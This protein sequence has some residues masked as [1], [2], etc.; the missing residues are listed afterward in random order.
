MSLYR[1]LL[2]FHIDAQRGQFIDEVV[3]APE[4][5]GVLIFSRREAE[6][7]WNLFFVDQLGQALVHQKEIAA[8][9]AARGREPVWY[10]PDEDDPRLPDAAQVVG[11]NTWMIR[12]RGVPWQGLPAG[13]SLRGVASPG[14]AR[15]FNQLYVD[16]YWNSEPA[17]DLALPIPDDVPSRQPSDTF[18]VRHWLLL[19]ADRPVALLTTITRQGMSAVYNVGTHPQFKRRGYATHAI[20]AVLAELERQGGERSFLLTECDPTLAPFYARMGYEPV[21]TG[22]FLKM[23]SGKY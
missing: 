22:R 21:T 20:L 17:E 3:A 8:A 11:T 6:P 14:D 2:A 23:R 5:A 1:E 12:R 15:L 7:M 9:F 13:L 4:A 16:V 18:A 19:L 10:L